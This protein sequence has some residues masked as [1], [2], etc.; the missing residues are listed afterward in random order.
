MVKWFQVLQMTYVKLWQFNICHLFTHIV[1]F[2]WP[3]DRT[4]S[5]APTTG[6]SG[7]GS[8]GDEGVVHIP[9]ISKAEASQ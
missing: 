9:Q 5:G 3:I 4:K 2:I 6:Q 8:D 1:C 7:P